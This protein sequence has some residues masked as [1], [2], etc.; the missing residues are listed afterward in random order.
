MV[1]WW[2]PA[3]ALGSGLM[4]NSIVPGTTT[5]ATVVPMGIVNGVRFV[6]CGPNGFA[7]AAG[8]VINTWKLGLGVSYT[9]STSVM[10]D[11]ME[12]F[13]KIMICWL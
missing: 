10:A 3:G 9:I 8:W 13:S 5:L 6:C 11:V 4:V 12:S 1:F 2:I 7:A